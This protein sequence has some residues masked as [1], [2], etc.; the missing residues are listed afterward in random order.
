MKPSPCIDCPDRVFGCWANCDRYREWKAEDD[1]RRDARKKAKDRE[2]MFND[3]KARSVR[4]TKGR[5]K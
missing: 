5:Q 3:F 2:Y 1:K 4:K